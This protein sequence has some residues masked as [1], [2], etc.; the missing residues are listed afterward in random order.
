MHHSFPHSILYWIVVALALTAAA[1]HYVMVARL[2]RAGVRV[3]L[4]FALPSEQ[5]RIHSTYRSMAPS[6]N[7]SLWPF[8]GFFLAVGAMLIALI[9]TA[10]VP[11]I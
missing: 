7:W 6:G 4:F 10:F 8:Y 11:V 1:F 3:K 9:V 5:Y 2:T